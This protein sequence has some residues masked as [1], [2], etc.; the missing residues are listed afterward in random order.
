VQDALAAYTTN[1]AVRAIVLT[2]AGDRAFS[3]GADLSRAPENPEAA[4]AERRKRFA[5]TL[6][7][8]LDFPKPAIA[9]VN[10]AACGA[11]MMLALLCDT[12]VAADSAKFSL[13]EINAGLT[14]LPGSTIV[15]RRFGA[16]LASDLV[17]SGRFMPADEALRHGVVR[18][19]VPQ[20][21]LEAEA[22]RTAL[23]RGKYDARAYAADK[24]WL[25]RELRVELAAA[26]EAAAEYHRH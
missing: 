15:S 16:A 14:T 13:P 22:Q 8:L 5:E 10:G 25:N 26:L 2:G 17:L 21:E 7:A 19:V 18:K 9:A 1:D 24:R 23:A 6:F 3:A 20:G 11:G 4:M 12:I